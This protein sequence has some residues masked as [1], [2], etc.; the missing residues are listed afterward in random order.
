MNGEERLNERKFFEKTLTNV[1]EGI[2]IEKWECSNEELKINGKWQIEKHRIYGG[3]SDGIDVI[4]I[5][6]GYL[7]FIVV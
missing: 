5:D 6:N 3:L 4:K 2:Y 1:N 7:S